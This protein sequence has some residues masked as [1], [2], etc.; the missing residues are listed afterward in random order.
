VA[1]FARLFAEKFTEYSVI[2]YDGKTEG[3]LEPIKTFD[4]T[5]VKDKGRATASFIKN[6]VGGNTVKR[7]LNRKENF[8]GKMPNGEYPDL[9][10][11]M[12]GI[13]DAL[14]NDASKFVTPDVFY[15]HYKELI[16]LMFSKSP[17][18]I[19]LMTPTFNGPEKLDEYA[20]AVRRIAK[21][22][23][24]EFIDLFE[25]WKEHYN[26]SKDR[27]GQGDWLSD[28]KGDA[29]HPTPNG[30]KAMAKYIFEQIIK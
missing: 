25:L 21:E 2:R 13:N 7:A 29:C 19:M 8:I 18:A 6:G 15:E 20:Q 10:V 14:T 12:F 24:L 23:G 1:V 11:F 30:A 4:K 22:Y 16:E 5:V 26:P 28:T 9:T 3:A 27:Y 17:S